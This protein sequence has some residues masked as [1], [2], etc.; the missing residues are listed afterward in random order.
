METKDNVTLTVVITA[1]P[2]DTMMVITHL[3]LLLYSLEFSNSEMSV[4]PAKSPRLLAI[5]IIEGL[6]DVAGSDAEVLS[7]LVAAEALLRDV[8]GVEGALFISLEGA[9]GG[10]SSLD[11]VYMAHVGCL[12]RSIGDETHRDSRGYLKDLCAVRIRRR[13]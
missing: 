10:S 4:K 7:P 5:G 9:P 1:A 8:E 6:V 3:M 12:L 13:S 11:F 2:A